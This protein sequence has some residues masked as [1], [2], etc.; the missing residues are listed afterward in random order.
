MA[1]GLMRIICS[2]PRINTIIGPPTNKVIQQGE[3]V[4]L[5]VSP[6]YEGY[7]SA[8]GRAV[9]AAELQAEQEFF[10]ELLSEI[11]IRKFTSGR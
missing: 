6:R 9:V 1:T 7:T 4:M 10:S 3:P 11:D 8:I 5:G 2:G